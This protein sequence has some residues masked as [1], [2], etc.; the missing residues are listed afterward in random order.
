MRVDAR[1]KLGLVL[2]ALVACSA[3]PGPPEQFTIPKGASFRA[4]TDTL[5]AHGVVR[6]ALVF[7]VLARLRRLDRS[8]KAGTYRLPRDSRA[9]NVIEALQQ[10]DELLVKVTIPEGL[11]VLEMAPLVAEQL[12]VPADSFAAAARDTAVAHGTAASLP[13]PT[14][15]CPA[16]RITAALLG[17]GL[18][19][20][21]LTR[22]RRRRPLRQQQGG[23]GRAGEHDRR[24]RA[25]MSSHGVCKPPRVLWVRKQ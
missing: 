22:R 6:N 12:G 20:R 8:V 3:T 1:I 5:T 23:H 13:S 21:R 19:G 17:G 11:T 14:G 4:I 7:K 2:A 24:H 9:W 18:T 16:S 10:G 25:G 15:P